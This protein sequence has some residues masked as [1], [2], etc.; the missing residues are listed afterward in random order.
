MACPSRTVYRACSAVP[1]AV[2]T[3]EWAINR[4]HPCSRAASSSTL[5]SNPG[6]RLQGS[7]QKLQCSL[8]GHEGTP[9]ASSCPTLTFWL[10]QAAA[11]EELISAI[12]RYAAEI[13]DLK[14]KLAEK[15]AQ[16]MGGFGSPTRL[17]DMDDDLGLPMVQV[18]TRN[19]CLQQVVHHT[20]ACNSS[21]G[22]A[23]KVWP[24]SVSKD[25][26]QMCGACR[27][28]ALDHQAMP[29]QPL[30][31]FPH[32]SAVRHECLVQTVLTQLQHPAHNGCPAASEQA[33]GKHFQQVSPHFPS[34]QVEGQAHQANK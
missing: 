9:N 2:P 33:A 13:A 11:R 15:D 14:W 10:S 30:R 1:T 7:I 16:L 4:N 8:E 28:L 31:P 24:C 5:P 23:A 17:K 19:A 29:Q 12:K 20:H 26:V 32:P 27:L 3:C 18:G 21:G 34:R 25:N 22:G 6:V